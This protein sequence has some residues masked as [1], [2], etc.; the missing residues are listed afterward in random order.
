MINWK[1]PEAVREL[2]KTL[3]LHD[4]NLK[5]DIP[6]NRLC[7][8]VTNRANYIHWINDLLTM[9]SRK[10]NEILGIDMYLI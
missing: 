1:N 2:T 10:S 6:L 5:W 9:E 4:F 8:P 7:P 3:L